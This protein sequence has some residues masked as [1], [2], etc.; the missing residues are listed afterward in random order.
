MGNSKYLD[1]LS[2]VQY[3]ALSEKLWKIQ[4][5]RCFI[6]GEKID[7]LLNQTNIDHITPLANGG[8]DDEKNFALTHDNCNKSKQDADLIVARSMAK[9]TKILKKQKLIKKHLH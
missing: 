9:L 6:C 4:N 7:L 2:K 1:S 5:Q 8:K 3:T